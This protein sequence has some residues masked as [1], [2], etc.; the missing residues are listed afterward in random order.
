MENIFPLTQ[1]TLTHEYIFYFKESFPTIKLLK[2]HATI[3]YLTLL[4]KSQVVII[5]LLASRV[6]PLLITL[7]KT[8]TIKLTI[9]LIPYY[10]H[11]LGNQPQK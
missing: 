9:Q 1:A 5:F 6:H 4:I 10:S 11:F 2:L 7:L 3:A 8:L